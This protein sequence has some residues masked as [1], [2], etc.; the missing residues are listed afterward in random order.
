MARYFVSAIDAATALDLAQRV[1]QGAITRSVAF[2]LLTNNHGF[3]DHTADAHLNCYAHLLVGT[4]WKATI[5]EPALRSMLD[6]IGARGANDLFLALQAVQG[7]LDYFAGRGKNLPGLRAV[8]QEYRPRLLPLTEIVPKPDILANKV[9]ASIA[10]DPA[11]RRARLAAAPKQP[12]WTV[13]LIRHFI[14]NPDVIAE[15][16]TRADGE[17]E[18]CKAPAPFNRRSNGTPFLEVHHRIRLADG[19]DDTTENAIALCPNCHRQQHHG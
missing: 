3:K 4:G 12:R 2:D 9:Q 14:R 19:G 13:G 6:L 7:H 5:G 10:D 11:K 17:C 1:E 18:Q 8:L 15:V 16:L